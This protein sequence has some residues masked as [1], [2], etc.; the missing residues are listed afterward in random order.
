MRKCYFSKNPFCE[1]LFF[2]S[3]QFPRFLKVN[4]IVT[5]RLVSIKGSQ[6]SSVFCTS[7]NA[8]GLIGQSF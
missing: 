6:K 4:G 7:V 5:F 2:E 1:H 8:I 3:I